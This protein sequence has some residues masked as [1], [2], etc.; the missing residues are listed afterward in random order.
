MSKPHIIPAVQAIDPPKAMFDAIN[1]AVAD[2][3]AARTE[4]RNDPS[5][6]LVDAA[7]EHEG[8]TLLPTVP[9]TKFEAIRVLMLIPV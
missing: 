9:A 2:M 7:I 8:D 6:E 4:G 3:V 5:G 1:H